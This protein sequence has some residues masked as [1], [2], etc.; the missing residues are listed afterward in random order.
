MNEKL[1]TTSE[2]ISTTRHQHANRT[3][4]GEGPAYWFF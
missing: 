3:T 4:P 1:V 2:S